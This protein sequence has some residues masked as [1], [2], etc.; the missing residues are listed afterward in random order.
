LILHPFC[1]W[2]IG[3]LYG[4]SS[5]ERA[6]SLLSGAAVH[7]ALQSIGL[8][9]TLIDV[10]PDNY[11]RAIREGGM[12]LAFNALHGSFGE[13]G[14]LQTWLE[15]EGIPYTG[16]NPEACRRA[17]D[18]EESRRLFAEA[19]L[20]VAR[21]VAI[22]RPDDPAART[23]RFPLFVKPASGGSSIGVS[24]V[25]DAGALDRAIEAAFREDSKVIVEERIVGRE[26]TV[27]VLG[28]EALGTIE[29]RTAREF[30]D[31]EAKYNDAATYEELAD[32]SPETTAAIE[33]AGVTAHRALGCAGFSRADIMLAEDG[34]YVLEMNAI[35]GMTK[36]SLLPKMAAKKGMPFPEFC[37]RIIKEIPWVKENLRTRFAS[38]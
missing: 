2:K 33:T 34:P 37:V 28:N 6:I 35:P 11:E 24:L 17:M 27:G 9:V 3:V 21:G 29:I 36:K 26:L 18:K 32:L 25:K 20:K 22:R 30:F 38:I 8:D 19:G 10:Q 16:S 12:D 1:S 4:G 14:V 7:E 13:D 5:S 23:L 15:K 31:Y